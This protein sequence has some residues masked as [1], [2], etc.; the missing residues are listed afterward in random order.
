MISIPT[1]ITGLVVLVLIYPYIA[2]LNYVFQAK[3]R[4]LSTPPM[5]FSFPL[6][7]PT[8]ISNVNSIRNKTLNKRTMEQIS[9]YPKG[10]TIR[11]QTMANHVTLTADPE[12]IKTILATKFNDF[13][14]GLRYNIFFDLFGDGIFTLDGK[15]WQHSRAMLRPQFTRDQISHVQT[16]EDHLQRIIHMFKE[17]EKAFAAGIPNPR[18]KGIDEPKDK[19]GRKGYAVD[20]QPLFF[21]LTIDTATEFLFG[22]SV[23]MLSGGNKK[24]SSSYEFGES[25][26]AAQETLTRRFMLQKFYWLING[27]EFQ[28][29]CT[30]CKNFAMSYVQLALERTAKQSDSTDEKPKSYVFLDELAKET[31][32]PVVLR[33]QALNILVAGRDTT[34]SLLSWVFLMLARHKDVFYKLRETIIRD[35]GEGTDPSAISF[36]TLKRCEYLRHVINETLRLYPT[37]PGNVRFATKDTSLPRGG[38][39][40]GDKPV[41]LAKNSVVVYSVYTTH[42]NPN[43]WGPDA[44]KFRPE[45]WMSPVAGSH[46]WSFLP[47]NGG[48]RICL[49]QQ[50]ALTEA[51]YVIV[52]LLQTFRDIDGDPSILSPDEPQEYASLTMA[53]A[54][55]VFINL[56]S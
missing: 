24:V 15:G 52:R 9:L 46:S 11:N 25:F 1:A 19:V 29:Q 38:G 47:F 26:N 44:D 7:I 17:N 22:E 42:R 10:L 3:R 35:F 27:K 43:I 6:G 37:V 8:T 13:S 40:N 41:F 55:G 39:K 4:G 33:D 50:F 18:I 45:R 53:P 21:K 16:I 49:G 20:I 2:H 28:D 5:R 31:R 32:D 34:A 51:S 48:P 54:N 12:N 56:Y 30:L 23:D 14:L 36:E